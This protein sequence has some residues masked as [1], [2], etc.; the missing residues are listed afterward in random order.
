LLG[1]GSSKD[2]GGEKR[3]DENVLHGEC[4]MSDQPN[5]VLNAQ[6]ESSK[7]LKEVGRC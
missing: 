7:G 4:N 6:V 2:C 5:R 1:E 3:S